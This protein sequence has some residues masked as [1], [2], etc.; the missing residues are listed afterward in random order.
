MPGLAQINTK[1]ASSGA[2]ALCHAAANGD[3]AMIDLL[4]GYGASLDE[5]SELGAAVQW[6][7]MADSG[8]AVE[9]LL[10][11]GANPNVVA[12]PSG[13]R[14]LPS[15]LVVAASMN[16]TEIC[17][18]L[19]ENGADAAARDTEGMTALHHAAGNGNA[20]LFRSL[21]LFNA[22][23]YAKDE[24]GQVAATCGKG[25]WFKSE[26]DAIMREWASTE[27]KGE[28]YWDAVANDTATQTQL[29]FRECPDFRRFLSNSCP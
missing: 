13:D 10:D 15:A 23:P 6:A 22:D 2:T 18:M 27:E 28:A 7:A 25:K 8:A 9:S 14:S 1:D 4:V 19:L 26:V 5:N 29:E 24:Q 20:P 16:Q 12:P 17:K 21:L 11:H 3:V